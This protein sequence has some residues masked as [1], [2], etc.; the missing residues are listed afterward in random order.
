MLEGWCDPFPG[1]YLH[2]PSQRQPSPTFSVVVEA[3]RYRSAGLGTARSNVAA[4]ATGTRR[5]S[6]VQ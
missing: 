5:R 4:K 1:Y 3:L 2:H 6:K